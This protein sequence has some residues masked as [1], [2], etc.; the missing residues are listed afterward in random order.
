MPSSP[1]LG[2]S[3]CVK[4]VRLSR[5]EKPL[6]PARFPVGK[7]VRREE[8]VVKEKYTEPFYVLLDSGCSLSFL[9]AKLINMFQKGIIGGVATPVTDNFR[10]EALLRNY[11]FMV[12]PAVSTDKIKLEFVFAGT[13]ANDVVVTVPT[14][15]FVFTMN[16]H[17]RSRLTQPGAG[18]HFEAGYERESLILP[19]IRRRYILGL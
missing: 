19:S 8:W 16:P 1:E 18:Y 4:E 17:R 9:P 11:L 2:W 6:L 14:D 5:F 10:V 13:R 7:W 15:P 3:V 12:P